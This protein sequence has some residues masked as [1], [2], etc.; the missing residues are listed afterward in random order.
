MVN[1]Q[2]WVESYKEEI[3]SVIGLYLDISINMLNA[4][5]S[6][7]IVRKAM[8]LIILPLTSDRSA[9]HVKQVFLSL[10]I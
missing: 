10:L 9:L 6:S 3:C 1:L 8:L 5:P 2:N 7:S 4:L